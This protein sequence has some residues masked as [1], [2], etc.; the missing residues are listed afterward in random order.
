MST[1]K[2]PAAVVI[3]AFGGVRPT[4]RVLGVSP[5]TVSR[6]NSPDR[7]KKH[8]GTIPAN[9]H[10]AIITASKRR[11]LGITPHHLIYGVP[12]AV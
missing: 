1:I 12:A 2:T 4:A 11:R 5:S 7:N 9:M 6:W 10:R 3:E 8:V